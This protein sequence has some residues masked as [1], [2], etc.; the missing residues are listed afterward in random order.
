MQQCPLTAVRVAALAL[1][2]D[3]ADVLAALLVERTA[4]ASY[5][6]AEQARRRAQGRKE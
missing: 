3:P 5:E 1:D 4:A 6:P 2:A